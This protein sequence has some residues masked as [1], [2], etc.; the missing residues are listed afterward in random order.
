VPPEG[1][2][3]DFDDLNL[4]LEESPLAEPE[5]WNPSE[6]EFPA[7]LESIMQPA[8]GE[9]AEAATPSGEAPPD[10]GESTG[11]PPGDESPAEFMPEE[12]PGDEVPAGAAA[13]PLGGEKGEKGEK[14]TKGGFA[15]LAYVQ[16][17]A[18]VLVAVALYLSASLLSSA[19][20]GFWNGIYLVLMAVLAFALWKTRRVWTTPE[21]SAPFTLMIVVSL[22]ALLTAVY[23]LGLELA[24]YDWDQKA[25]KAKQPAVVTSAAQLGPA[26]TIA[27]AWPIDVQLTARAEASPQAIGS[28]WMT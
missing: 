25:K 5:Q 21:V 13:E 10:G 27:A 1:Q 22:A 12:E 28:P 8:V 4:P 6:F 9:G 23:C 15:W 26:T 3:P 19:A 16:W 20:T 7:E 24:R 18:A 17:I 14:A 11:L 2:N